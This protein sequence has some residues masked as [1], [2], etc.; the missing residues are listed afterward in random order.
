VT[1]FT[2]GHSIHRD[3]YQEFAATVRPFLAC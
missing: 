1:T 3:R 2:C